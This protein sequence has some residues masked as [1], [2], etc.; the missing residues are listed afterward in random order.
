MPVYLP[1]CSISGNYEWTQCSGE[2]C[3]CVEEGGKPRT[4]TVSRGQIQ[5][6]ESGIMAGTVN[7]VCANRQK[8][9]ICRDTCRNSTC[10]T[11][12]DV[13]CAADPCDGCAV[14]FV[15]PNGKTVDCHGKHK[16]QNR[17]WSARYERGAFQMLV[18]KRWN[19]VFAKDKCSDIISIISL[20]NAV[21]LIIP[22]AEEMKII[23][24]L[25]PSAPPVVYVSHPLSSLPN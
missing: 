11:R 2:I 17:C 23:S 8:P 7:P 18:N 1:T 20:K 16:G 22:D 24:Q 5:C 4:E 14:R 13:F 21:R 3:W 9:A 19:Q 25:R 15:D 6:N 10:G 12:T